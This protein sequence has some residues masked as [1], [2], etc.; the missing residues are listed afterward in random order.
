MRVR[1]WKID[2]K[3]KVIGMDVNTM[4]ILGAIVVLGLAILFGTKINKTAEKKQVIK[5]LNPFYGDKIYNGVNSIG[6]FIASIGQVFNG[7]S[8]WGVPVLGFAFL[9]AIG[10]ILAV[11][12]IHY[13]LDSNAPTRV[14]DQLTIMAQRAAIASGR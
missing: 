4:V 13:G 7:E 5:R 8:T 10:V 3:Q 6:H 14:T 9:A 1:F 11:V 2:R 12:S